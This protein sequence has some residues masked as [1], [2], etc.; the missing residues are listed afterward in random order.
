MRAMDLSSKK[1]HMSSGSRSFAYH[2]PYSPPGIIT[3]LPVFTTSN[4]RLLFLSFIPPLA[5]AVQ[6]VGSQECFDLSFCER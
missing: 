4:H 6:S 2:F 3:R 1:M 5:V